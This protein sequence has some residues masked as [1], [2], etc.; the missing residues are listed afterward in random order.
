MSPLILVTN[1]DGIESQGLVAAASAAKR[2]GDI[3]VVAPRFHQSGMGRARPNARE[4]GVIETRE[5]TLTDGSKIEAYAVHGSPSQTVAYAVMEIVPRKP[6]FCISGVNEGENVGS[7]LPV[8]GTVGAAL[9]GAGFGIASMAISQSVDFPNPVTDWTMGEYFAEVVLRQMIA[10][11]LPDEALIVNLNIPIGAT[12]STKIMRTFDSRRSHYY[13]TGVDRSD[14]NS[15]APFL[16]EVRVELGD[17]EPGSDIAALFVE[18]AVS[19]SLLAR[20]WAT[21]VAW[22][23]PS[24]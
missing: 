13:F 23:L 12:P 15:P 9:E 6:D 17:T 10:N 1:D 14:K 2:C 18:H 16:E 8:S 11:P 4:A 3:I 19:L 21:D 20:R 5:L 22:P 7:I 24:A